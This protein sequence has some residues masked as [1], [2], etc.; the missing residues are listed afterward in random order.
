MLT[1]LGSFV[2]KFDL[3]M[4]RGIPDAMLYES[5]SIKEAQAVVAA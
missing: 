2:I 3:I 4:Q 5:V 1:S